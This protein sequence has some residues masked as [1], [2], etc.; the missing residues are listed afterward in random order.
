[1]S[2]PTSGPSDATNGKAG[3]TSTVPGPAPHSSDK[4]DAT[5]RSSG[6]TDARSAPARPPKGGSN[7]NDQVTESI[8]AFY[9]DTPQPDPSTNGSSATPGQGDPHNGD[10][11]RVSRQG[12]VPGSNGGGGHQGAAGNG[13][14]GSGQPRVATAGM[15]GA[16]APLRAPGERVDSNT[17]ENKFA[18]RDA[19]QKA[20]QTIAAAAGRGPRRARLQLKKVEPWSVM[21][22]SFAASLVLFIAFVVATAILYTVLDAV[23]VFDSIN[24]TI[25]SLTTSEG[26]GAD[27]GFAIDAKLVIGGAALLGAV[28]MVLFTALATL[29]AFVYNI[30]ADLAGGVEVTLAERE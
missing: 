29:G 5:N 11:T 6:N 10:A 13:S 8:P 27:S 20:R 26:G 25:K 28:N 24:E 21:K 22:F 1:M 30:C 17:A 18:F 3:Q 15:P 2:N 12:N 19:A 7:A 4:G 14:G 16:S 9:G 23:G